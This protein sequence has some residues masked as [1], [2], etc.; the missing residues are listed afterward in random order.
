DLAAYLGFL[1][2]K[3]IVGEWHVF[4]IQAK[5]FARLGMSALV[6]ELSTEVSFSEGSEGINGN[7]DK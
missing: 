1:I 6:R 3:E 4:N 5:S 7:L 2:E